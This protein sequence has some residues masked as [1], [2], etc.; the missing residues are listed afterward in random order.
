LQA[1]VLSLLQFSGKRLPGRFSPTDQLFDQV[2]GSFRATLH[3]V[4]D[5]QPQKLGLPQALLGELLDAGAIAGEQKLQGMTRGKYSRV[6]AEIAMIKS[7]LSISRLGM[8]SH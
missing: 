7:T 4:G 5:I 6:I 8:R 3:R 2:L 1:L